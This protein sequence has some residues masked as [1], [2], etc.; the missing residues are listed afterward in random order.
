MERLSSKMG[1][2]SVLHNFLLFAFF[3]WSKNDYF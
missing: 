3:E 1:E 2:L